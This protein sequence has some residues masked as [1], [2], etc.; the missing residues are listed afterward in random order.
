MAFDMQDNKQKVN[1]NKLFFKYWFIKKCTHLSL[2]DYI[3]ICVCVCVLLFII[4][5]L[6]T[7]NNNSQY[8]NKKLICVYQKLI[9]NATLI[10]FWGKYA[11]VFFKQTAYVLLMAM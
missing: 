11:K 10:I 8:G 7:V 5:S 9:T 6:R 4:F 3:Y 1:A 2:P